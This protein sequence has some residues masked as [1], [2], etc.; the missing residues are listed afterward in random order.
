M[1]GF[2]SVYLHFAR[3]VCS[4]MNVVHMIMAV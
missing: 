3:S 2:I 1:L 4:I